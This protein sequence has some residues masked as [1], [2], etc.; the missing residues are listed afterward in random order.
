ME[1]F[2][3]A[4]VSRLRERFG[5]NVFDA[6]IAQAHARRDADGGITVA[7]ANDASAR[8]LEQNIRESLHQ[9]ASDRFGDIPSIHFCVADPNS[10][11]APAAIPAAES[12]AVAVS[13]RKSPA[14]RAKK[15]AGPDG[16]TNLRPDLTFDTFLPGR[17]NELGLFAAKAVSEGD[18]NQL[19][20]LLFLYG[21]TGMGKTHLSHAVGNRY[22]A[23]HPE[24][25]ARYVM[26]RDFMADVVKACRLD[27]HE[28]FKRRYEGLDLLI[29]D[30]IQY[31]GGDMKRTQEE[32]FFLFNKL[33]SENKIIVITSDRAP[34]QLR[35][36]P[37]R[38]TSRL[39]CGVPAYLAPPEL[40][41]REAILRQKARQRGATMDDK[42][43]RFIA[44]KIKSNVRELE[45]AINQVLTTCAFLNKTPTLDICRDAL[46]D[47]LDSAGEA[48]NVDDIKKKVAEFFR[49]RVS[50]LSSPSRRRSIARPRHLAIYL[51][52]QLTNLSLPEIGSHFGDREHTTVLHS[53]RR[54]ESELKANSQTQEDIKLLEMLVKS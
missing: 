36:L 39:R 54:V 35:N 15:Q 17:A 26:A 21:R 3:S 46:A 43:I 13:G 11:S 24:R 50:D 49:L 25:R 32:L 19:S 5:R 22:L 42:I 16:K 10:D 4:C 29:V 20:A 40:E 7:A 9:V 28:Q 12:S 38:L 48:V 31:L 1:D 34:A 6:F 27:Q 51:C 30:D 41:L 2:W 45:G 52:R 33:H 14:G 37:E 44:E 18:D 53:C 23:L 8:W 47:T